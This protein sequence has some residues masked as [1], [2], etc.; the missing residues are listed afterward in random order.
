MGAFQQ[1]K[2]AMAFA[3]YPP[4]IRELGNASGLICSWSIVLALAIKS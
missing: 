2:D 3:F 4:P 1:I